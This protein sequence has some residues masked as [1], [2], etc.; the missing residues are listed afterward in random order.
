LVD[1]YAA[2]VLT[3]AGF[4][5]RPG[6][7]FTVGSPPG[8]IMPVQF[9][10]DAFDPAVAGFSVE[11]PI[12]PAASMAFHAKGKSRQPA[13]AVAWGVVCNRVEVPL[14]IAEP[15]NFGVRTLRT[16]PVAKGPAECGD[17]LVR[18]PTA[19]GLLTWWLELQ[20]RAVVME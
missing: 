13:P 6:R 9:R 8:N 17:A 2:P 14:E 5:P 16:L 7:Q 20:D 4:R 19:D 18:V 12:V 15:L 3:G 10:P 11:W 1:D